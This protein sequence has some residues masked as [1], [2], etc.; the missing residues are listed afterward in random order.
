MYHRFPADPVG[1]SAQCEYI[2]RH[3]TPVPLR[4]LARASR[5][6]PPNSVAI[7]VDD[8]YED[9]AAHAWPVFRR[10]EIPATVYLVS[11]FLDRRLWI[12]TDQLRYLIE[13]TAA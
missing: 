11:E 4:L 7:T 1:L 13:H 12:W 5:E 2:R 6:L 8:G 10:F 9:F 3:Y